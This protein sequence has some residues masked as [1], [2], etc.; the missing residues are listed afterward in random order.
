M[1]TYTP[2]LLKYYLKMGLIRLETPDVDIGELESFFCYV[3]NEDVHIKHKR[4]NLLPPAKKHPLYTGN[5]FGH[6]HSSDQ[7]IARFR[8][9]LS[10]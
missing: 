8:D 2:T 4:V 6:P 10:E 5:L 9:H 7:K 1:G 3:C